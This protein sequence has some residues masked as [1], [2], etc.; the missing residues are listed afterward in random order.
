MLH[1]DDCGQITSIG[2]L[3]AVTSMYYTLQMIFRLC[4]L[5]NNYCGRF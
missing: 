2:D 3:Q 5:Y 1:A 4:A